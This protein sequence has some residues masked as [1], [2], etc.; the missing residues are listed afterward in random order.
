[1]TDNVVIRLRSRSPYLSGSSAERLIDE[2]ADEIERP[3]VRLTV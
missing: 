2:L 3:A 1:M